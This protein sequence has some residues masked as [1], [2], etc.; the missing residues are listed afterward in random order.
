MRTLALLL[1]A[2]CSSN[3]D[4][5]IVEGTVVAV[6]VPHSVT[7]AH[8]D[9]PGFM[10]AM[11]MP[12]KV[13][14]PALLHGVAAGDRV[15]A[16]LAVGESGSHLENLRVTGKGVPPR[17]ADSVVAPLQPGEQLPAVQVPV[18][19]GQTWTLGAGQGA[20]TALGFIY[21]RCP[22]PD[23]CP[24]VVMRM[25]ALQAVMPDDARILLVTLDPDFDSL[26][27]LK[28]FA[29]QSGVGERWAFGRV[30]QAELKD[31]ATRAGLVMTQE[32]DQILHALRMLVLDADG[33]LVA[34]HDD[35]RWEA[36]EVASE[37]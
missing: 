26:E 24:A 27:V 9:I 7:I 17:M 14:D 15:Y 10:P 16:R 19:T 32:G 8:Q 20:P 13:E 6:D 21:T 23:Y 12:F 30:E 36:A 31:L 28:G 11:T 34:R 35:G 18:H 3:V 4:R 2:A 29:E 33:K 25:Q 5:Y 22:L 37:L 1:L